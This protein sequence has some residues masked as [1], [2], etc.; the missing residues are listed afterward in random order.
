MYGVYFCSVKY[1]FLTSTITNHRIEKLDTLL[2]YKTCWLVS[3]K[4]QSI[5]TVLRTIYLDIQFI[6]VELIQ[7]PVMETSIPGLI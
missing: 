6:I 4:N 3:I 7:Y 1:F 2:C 5:G